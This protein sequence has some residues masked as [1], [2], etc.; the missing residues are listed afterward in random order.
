MHI[1]ILEYA[2]TNEK[3]ALQSAILTKKVLRERGGNIARLT[4]NQKPGNFYETGFLAPSTILNRQVL[5]VEGEEEV[6]GVKQLITHN[7]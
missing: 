2:Y 3:Y 1:S 7:S 6:E 4:G 5:K